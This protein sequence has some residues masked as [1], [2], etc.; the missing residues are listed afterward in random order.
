MSSNSNPASSAVCVSGWSRHRL[1]EH[2]VEYEV[3]EAHA[4]KRALVLARRSFNRLEFLRFR[5]FEQHW[6]AVRVD[7][8]AVTS[9]REAEILARHAPGTRRR[10]F[11][12]ASTL[13]RSPS[14]A[15]GRQHTMAFRHLDYRRLSTRVPPRRRSALAALSAAGVSPRRPT[16]HHRT[17]L[18]DGPSRASGATER[19]V[20]RAK[21]CSVLQPYIMGRVGHRVPIGWRRRLTV[22]AGWHGHAWS[23]QLGSLP[24]RPPR[25]TPAARASTCDTS[26]HLVVGCRAARFASE[27]VRLCRDEELAAASGRRVYVGLME[28]RPPGTSREP[29]GAL[30]RPRL[31]R[32]RSDPRRAGRRTLR[33]PACP[34]ARRPWGMRLRRTSFSSSAG[35]RTR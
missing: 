34:R 14:C 19:R 31:E 1:D 20:S 35:R 27:V 15:V 2:N 13:E 23:V 28:L 22:D 26:E 8:A 33:R 17:G 16:D 3:F 24:S 30:V 29:P 10:S 12:T 4:P 11:P 25:S 6:W 9:A 18:S 21:P 32:G 5:R 7:G